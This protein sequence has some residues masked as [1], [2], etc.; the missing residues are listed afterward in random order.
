MYCSIR[1]SFFTLP[2]R[3]L[4]FVYSPCPYDYFCFIVSY[5]WHWIDFLILYLLCVVQQKH[6]KRKL[7]HSEYFQAELYLPSFHL[8]VLNFAPI[9][10]NESFLLLICQKF[11]IFLLHK[12]WSHTFMPVQTD[13]LFYVK[14]KILRFWMV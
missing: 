3:S 4:V 7:P 8:F 1:W 9:R 5:V 2:L 14:F 6:I 12:L 10:T 11:P 13:E